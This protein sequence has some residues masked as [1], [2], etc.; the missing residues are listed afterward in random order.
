M[1]IILYLQSALSPGFWML[2][3]IKSASSPGLIGPRLKILSAWEGRVF[4]GV[5]SGSIDSC[6]ANYSPLLRRREKDPRARYLSGKPDRAVIIYCNQLKRLFA[7]S[8][9]V[10][11]GIEASLRRLAHYDYWETGCAA[12][13]FLIRGLTFWSMARESSR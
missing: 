1:L 11:G 9:I 4:F 7:H 10:I 13:F 12:R 5:T 6:L 8:P 2:R 3:V